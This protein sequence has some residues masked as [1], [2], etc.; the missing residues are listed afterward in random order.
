MLPTEMNRIYTFLGLESARMV[1]CLPFFFSLFP[2]P[3][4]WRR[5]IAFESGSLYVILAGLELTM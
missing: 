5:G 3:Y 2:L 1:F 4:L